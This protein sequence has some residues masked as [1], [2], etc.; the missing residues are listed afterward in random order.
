MLEFVTPELDEDAVAD[1]AYAHW[2]VEGPWQRLPGENLNYRGRDG[3]LKIAL[4][5]E[6]QLQCESMMSERLG[7]A[8]VPVPEL[9]PTVQS[10]ASVAVPLGSEIATA[11][12][13][14]CC[15]LYTSPSPRD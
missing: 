11:R 14:T 4:I 6:D 3:V 2:G 8:G 10:K 13:F 15:L 1:L 5:S 12:M 9:Q 7:S